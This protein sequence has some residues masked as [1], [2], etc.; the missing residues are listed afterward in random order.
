[1]SPKEDTLDQKSTTNPLDVPVGGGMALPRPGTPETLALEIPTRRPVVVMVDADATRAAARETWRKALTG[2]AAHRGTSVVIVSAR[3]IDRVREEPGLDEIAVLGLGQAAYS[4]RA[5]EVRN[6][7][8]SDD[9][10]GL[11][12]KV[13]DALRRI[14]E[15]RENFI[16]EDRGLSVVVH[17][18]LADKSVAAGVAEAWREAV[19]AIDTEGRLETSTGPSAVE[20]R[21]AGA[22]KG[23]LVT[24]VLETDFSGAMPVYLADELGGED[25]FVAMGGKALTIIMAAKPRPTHA[26]SRLAPEAAPEFLGIISRR[27][28][29]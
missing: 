1:M 6:L 23:D 22:G 7:I 26:R 24:K 16:V 14:L 25:G 3:P 29:G 17:S 20:V 12:T 21:A 27:P 5:G 11:V 2:L 4:P 8:G 10:K 19:A 28:T 13:R 15:G 18:A 9:A